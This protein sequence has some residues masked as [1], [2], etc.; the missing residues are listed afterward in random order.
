MGESPDATM[1]EA[2]MGGSKEKKPNR[3]FARN[4]STLHGLHALELGR[5]ANGAIAGGLQQ[6]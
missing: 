1:S 2:K 6:G 5:G 4:L 3:P